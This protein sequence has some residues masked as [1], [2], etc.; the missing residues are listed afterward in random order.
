MIGEAPCGCIRKSWPD[1]VV[2]TQPP[3]ST[4]RHEWMERLM[5]RDV[6]LDRPDRVIVI[7][8]IEDYMTFGHKVWEKQL[9]ARGYDPTSWLVYEEDYGYPTRVTRVAT[10]CI[11]RGS[12]TSSVSLPFSL[13]AAERLPPR[14]ASFALM[15]Y[16]VPA[17]A[18]I[19]KVSKEG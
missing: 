7:G 13:L 4:V 17:R 11:Q 18:Y 19:N 2:V 12:S 15:D 8:T 16:K 9:F 14:L 5:P 10:L 3:E 1:I 6:T